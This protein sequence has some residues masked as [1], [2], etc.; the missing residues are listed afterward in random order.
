LREKE[1]V[2]WNKKDKKEGIYNKIKRGCD[3]TCSLMAGNPNLNPVGLI[4]EVPRSGLEQFWNL[5]LALCSFYYLDITVLYHLDILAIFYHLNLWTP[6]DQYALDHNEDKRKW[7]SHVATYIRILFFLWDVLRW[8]RK[9]LISWILSEGKKFLISK[10]FGK[11]I[12]KSAPSKFWF[13]Y[14]L[15]TRLIGNRSLFVF[16]S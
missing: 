4:T 9:I 14:C 5:Q 1:K 3:D 13:Y 15:L 11:F 6:L 16:L 2:R 12:V 7:K 10:I 8:V